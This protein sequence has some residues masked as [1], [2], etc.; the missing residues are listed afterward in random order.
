MGIVLRT[1]EDYLQIIRAHYMKLILQSVHNVQPYAGTPNASVYI[2]KILH[3][4]RDF[5]EKSPDDAILEVL[6]A[7]YDALAYDNQWTAYTC[8]Q[9]KQA[10]GILNRVKTQLNQ[11]I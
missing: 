1:S 7:F 5:E 11:M 4:I 2:H 8:T 9:F 6:F 10:E 3:A